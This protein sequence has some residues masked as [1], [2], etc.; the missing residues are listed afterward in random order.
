MWLKNIWSWGTEMVPRAPRKVCAADI[1]GLQKRSNAGEVLYPRIWLKRHT[2]TPF[3]VETGRSLP[4][5]QSCNESCSES[6]AEEGELERGSCSG[7]S[8]GGELQERCPRVLASSSP[9]K[10]P[11]Y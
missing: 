4:L 1:G 7:Q 10:T 8:A 2:G 5:L 3:E 11:T 6:E 9:P